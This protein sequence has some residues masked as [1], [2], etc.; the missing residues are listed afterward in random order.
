M[1]RLVSCL[2]VLGATFVDLSLCACGTNDYPTT[3]PPQMDA[4][5][6]DSG[7]AGMRDGGVD[8]GTPMPRSP[9]SPAT[10]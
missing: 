4:G 8:A 7:D 3:L 6:Q 9:A 1:T 2:G 5:T 10:T